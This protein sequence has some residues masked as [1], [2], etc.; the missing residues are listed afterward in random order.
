MV[1][2]IEDF[3]VG[4]HVSFTKKFTED[5]M[6]RFIEIIGD[7]NPLHVD[8]EFAQRSTTDPSTTSFIR[9]ENM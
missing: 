4:Q 3:A 2:R 7:V 5:D 6:Q 9:R 8:E 1:A